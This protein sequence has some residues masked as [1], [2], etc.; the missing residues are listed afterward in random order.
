M[1]SVKAREAADTKIFL[2]ALISV[3]NH[4][5]S[6]DQCTMLA[7]QEKSYTFEWLDW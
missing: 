3:S 2:E 5:I 4:L 6:K 1:L 7:L